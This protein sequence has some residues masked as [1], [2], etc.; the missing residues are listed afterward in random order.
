MTSSMP[1]RRHTVV[2]ITTSYPR[3]PGDLTGTAVEPIA[4]GVAARGHAVHV[5]APW[6]PLVRRPEREGNVHFHFY[7]YAPL[8][9]LNVF[10]YAG[11][12]RADVSMRPA[13]YAVAPLALI[14]AH[15]LVRRIIRAHRATLLH[16]H[17]AIPGGA[18]AA[19]A[20]GRLPIVVSL[21]GSDLF[22]AER[23]PIARAAAGAAF[24][25][26]DRVTACS[27]DLRDRAVAL[28]AED[29]RT[30]TLLHG[31]DV[32]RFAPDREVRRR[33]RAAHGLADGTE[34]V[35]A[36]GRLVRKKGFEY[37][38]DAVARLAPRRPALRLVLA[39]G[40]D[41]DGELRARAAAGGVADRV[42]WLG[43]VPHD[44]VAGW[45]AAADVAAAPSVVDD[46]GNVDGLPNTILEA[47]ATATPVV[48]T[49][50]GGIASVAV[51]RETALVVPERD[52]ERLAA[53]IE[54]LLGDAGLRAAIGR[55]ARE[56]M[57]REH[58]WERVAE[59]FETAYELAAV[60]ARAR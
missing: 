35:F 37:L 5:V 29:A 28:G 20:A 34:V 50:A 22:V 6:H 41:L 13:A 16:A 60:R 39:G 12:L 25:R 38:I 47:L 23:N 36:V 3:F 30:E 24:R 43:A 49:H 8:R 40:G 26:A 19:A 59:R 11:A 42:T 48:A 33:V 55:A 54:A 31:V 14:A 32:S 44:Q 15:R 18:T 58:T 56:R 10:G 53:A 45:L 2:L 9:S 57:R 21:H 51:H 17:W 1:R 4:H 52:A 27:T 7:R 46:A